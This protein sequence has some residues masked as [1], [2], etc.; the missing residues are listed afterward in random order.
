MLDRNDITSKFIQQGYI[1]IPKLFDLEN[2][3]RLK[4]I[5]ARALDRRRKEY[6]KTHPIFPKK[7]CSLPEQIEYFSDYSQVIDYLLNTIA[8]QRILSILDYICDRQLFFHGLVYF[9]NPEERSWRGDWH[10]DG[11]INAPDDRTERLR[12]FSSS[13]VRVHLA[14]IADDNLEIVPGSHA[15]WDTSQEL[16]IRKGLNGKFSDSNL[17]PS[18]TRI[19]LQ[20]GD[21]VFF[22]GYSIP[23]R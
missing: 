23:S 9:F 19:N 11:Q 6:L 2:I 22:D 8:D 5:C 13:F 14:L 1:I 7:T 16:E 3:D 15:R 12:I 17:M 20:P 4:S 18:P 10:R 21:A